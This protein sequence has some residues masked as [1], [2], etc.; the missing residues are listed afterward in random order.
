MVFL[1]VPALSS[2]RY[3]SVSGHP[4]ASALTPRR[5]GR[6]A[7]QCALRAGRLPVSGSPEPL[8]FPGALLRAAGGQ[9]CDLTEQVP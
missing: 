8:A 9:L 4:G 2:V 1:K 6:S 7:R 3:C 5:R